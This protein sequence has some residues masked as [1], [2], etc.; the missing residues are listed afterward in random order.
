[1]EK[2][3]GAEGRVWLQPGSCSGHPAWQDRGS[4]SSWQRTWGVCWVIPKYTEALWHFM[5]CQQCYH[6]QCPCN[7]SANL[8]LSAPLIQFQ[9][10]SP[11]TQSQISSP[12]IQAQISSQTGAELCDQ[13]VLQKAWR[14]PSH[15]LEV[16]IPF[17][18]E[19]SWS[20]WDAELQG[21]GRV[22]A[23]R[24]MLEPCGEQDR[25]WPVLHLGSQFPKP[26]F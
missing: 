10:S 26:R 5:A 8:I 24:G 16:S 22:T 19:T 17:P 6:P 7:R 4:C 18:G 2:L 15:S 12:L 25:A 21:Q 3:D 1:M 9:I 14:S 11:Q 23:H 13:Q 20:F